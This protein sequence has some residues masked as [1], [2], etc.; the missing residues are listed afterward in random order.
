MTS[1]VTFADPGSKKAAVSVTLTPAPG[2]HSPTCFNSH[3]M[4]YDAYERRYFNRERKREKERGR[5]HL[6]E[7]MLLEFQQVQFELDSASFFEL[8]GTGN[9]LHLDLQK[10]RMLQLRTLNYC[11]EYFFC[12]DYY[13]YDFGIEYSMSVFG[14]CIVVL[15]QLFLFS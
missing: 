10:N 3:V 14:I 6:D 7:R 12:F 13:R 9:T 15:L 8:D 11:R 4:F 5:E 1:R 2:R